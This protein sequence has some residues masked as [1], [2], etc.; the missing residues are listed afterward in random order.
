MYR[1]EITILIKVINKINIIPLLMWCYYN[2]IKGKYLTRTFKLILLSLH[3]L[4]NCTETF[5]NQICNWEMP[6]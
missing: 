6:H 3:L 5:F 4:H 2:D 1:L